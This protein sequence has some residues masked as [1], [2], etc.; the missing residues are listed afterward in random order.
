[1]SKLGLLVAAAALALAGW[2]AYGQCERDQQ[3]LTLSQD[4]Q[5]LQDALGSMEQKL[6]T[7]L[8]GS[9]A[10][11]SLLAAAGD[12]RPEQG[13]G[14]TGV[15]G[16]ATRDAPEGRAATTDERIASL[17]K[18]IARLESE[19]KDDALPSPARM[20]GRDSMYFNLDRAAK[21][22]D[23]D[24][25]QKSDLKDAMERGKRELAD[26]YGIENDNGETWKEIRK[27][28][29]AKVGGESGLSIAMPDF[30]KIQKFKKSRIPGSS[31]TFGEAEKRIK[32]DAF[33]NARRTLTPKQAKK[34]DKAHKDPLLG[35]S[36]SSAAISFTSIEI[37][38]D[39]K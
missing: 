23:L 16:L 26:L 9:A 7:A 12:L 27:P 30:G 20:F 13:D 6:D 15:A 1:M 5:D 11:P 2:V 24:E 39:D 17:E 18:T 34:W 32:E 29:M 3:L 4:N 25:R 10:R 33:A 28:K 36:G 22:M 19:K 37:G 14:S 35:S 21:S 8:R 38:S 31:E